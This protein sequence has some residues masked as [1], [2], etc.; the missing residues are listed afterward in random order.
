[1]LKMDFFPLPSESF[2]DQNTHLTDIT[3]LSTK[4]YENQLITP[5]TWLFA[6][7]R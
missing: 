2:F 6:I 5:S 4:V 1:M 7:L 3:I